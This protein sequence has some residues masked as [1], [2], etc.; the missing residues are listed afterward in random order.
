[1]GG[2]KYTKSV[3]IELQKFFENPKAVFVIILGFA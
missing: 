2:E 3:I 1:M